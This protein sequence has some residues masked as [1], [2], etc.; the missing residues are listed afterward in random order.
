MTSTREPRLNSC[1]IFFET[2]LGYFEDLADLNLSLD[3]KE[4]VPVLA[5]RP[6]LET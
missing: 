2:C 4:L 3:P 1:R 5:E 6:E